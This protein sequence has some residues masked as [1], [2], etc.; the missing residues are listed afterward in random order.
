LGRQFQT[1]LRIS[2]GVVLAQALLTAVIPAVQSEIYFIIWLMLVSG[3]LGMGIPVMFSLTTDLIPMKQRGVA[4]ALVTALAY[5]TAEL[6]SDEWT[7]E[8]FQARLLWILLGGTLGMGV[9][10][11]ARHPWLTALSQQHR[12]P[13]F[14]IGRFVHAKPDS[15]GLRPS[16]R[17]LG[18]IVVMFGIYFVDSL[19]FLRLLKIPGFMENTWQSPLFGNRLFIALTH[20]IGALIAGVLY[21]A[22]SER[23]L[24]FW[25][26]GIFALTHLQYSLH[27]RATGQTGVTL[28][29][30]M[31]YALAVSLYTVVNF[32][33]WAD[34]STPDTICFNSA[35]GV[36]F[37]AW[38]TTFLSTGLSIYWQG[39]GMSLERHIQIVD[40]VAIL[41]FLVMLVLAY[42][43]NLEEIA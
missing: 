27:L 19:G 41:L 29:L 11:F 43:K 24:F 14:A 8:F 6:L 13:E 34:L 28:S 32:A 37:S 33:L 7:F 26:L 15:A 25:I 4:A 9:L 22:I 38:T 16:R 10:A 30:P 42:L 40:S 36:A 12:Q 3:A 21:R 18:L 17:V 23:Q 1:K 31:L 5:T 35:L 20:V 2:F 39:S